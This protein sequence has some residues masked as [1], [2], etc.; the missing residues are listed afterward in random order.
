METIHFA[1][2]ILFRLNHLSQK[3]TGITRESFSGLSQAVSSCLEKMN[4][5]TEEPSALEMMIVGEQEA[6][7]TSSLSARKTVKMT[8]G[9]P[10]SFRKEK[11]YGSER[12]DMKECVVVVQYRTSK[13]KRM[14]NFWQ[15]VFYASG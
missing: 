9:M 5:R 15:A 10:C 14:K 4:F 2:A 12:S 7:K 6:Y 11:G 3:G 8:G 13:S 1:V